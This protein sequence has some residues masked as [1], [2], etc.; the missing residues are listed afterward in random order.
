MKEDCCD[1]AK[2]TFFYNFD[3]NISLNSRVIQSRNV[4][5]LVH[6]RMFRSLLVHTQSIVVVS[7]RYSHHLHSDEL[8]LCTSS[9]TDHMGETKE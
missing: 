3:T 5:V 7:D 2:Y 9:A 1:H 8:C 4:L 6:F